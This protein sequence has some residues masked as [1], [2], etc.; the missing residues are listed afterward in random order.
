MKNLSIRVKIMLGFLL[1]VTILII[2]GLFSIVQLNNVNKVTQ[3]ITKHWLPS[4]NYASAIDKSFTVYR[5]KEYRYILVFSKEDEEKMLKEMNDLKI[6]IDKAIQS[7]KSIITT[8]EGKS[9]FAAFERAYSN[10]LAENAKIIN[11]QQS[12]RFDEAKAILSGK[13]LEDYYQ[14]A[15]ILEKLVDLSING[16]SVASD[17]VVKTYS[18]SLILIFI[19]I[20]ISVLIS[21][22]VALFIAGII[23]SGIKKI[24]MAAQ[25]FEVGDMN[26]DLEIDGKDEIGRLAAAFKNLAETMNRISKSAKLI[27]KGDLTVEISKRSENDELLGSLSE[28]V[29]HLNEIVGQIVESANNVS[30]SSKEVNNTAIQLSQGANEQASSAEEISSSIEEMTTTIQQN[31][32]NASQTEK[33]AVVSSQSIEEVNQASLR[34]LEAIRQ[35]V[36]KIKIINNI[37]EKTDILAINAAIEAARAGEHGKGFAVVAAEVR[38]L[39][40]TSQKA[41]IEINQFS[42]GSLKITEDTSALMSKMIPDIK[43]TAQLVQEIAASSQEQS[44]GAGQISKAIEQLSQVTQQNSAAAEEM[45]SNSE[46]LASQAEVL[47]EAISFFKTSKESEIKSSKVKSKP[48]NEHIQ[49][50][51]LSQRYVT[52][53]VEKSQENDHFDSLFTKY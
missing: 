33:I 25:K 23:S 37:A 16:S 17:N 50:T 26:I 19:I 49:S 53:N 52:N 22:V 36:E 24:Q 5:V 51:L 31:S 21:I 30:L 40:E 2:L 11:L 6:E 38:K 29:S 13:S 43:R 41:A 8:T 27:S 1:V 44:A 14:V 7:Y 32:D 39:A 3:D 28:M 47:K 10:Y 46:E 15:S 9:T 35:I 48:V 20:G 45:S 18:S 34:S 42:A 4:L 12:N